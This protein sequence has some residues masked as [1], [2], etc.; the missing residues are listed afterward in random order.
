MN[1]FVRFLAFK[2][3]LLFSLFRRWTK[4]FFRANEE[5]KYKI[6]V[7]ANA[8]IPTYQLG[9]LSPLVEKVKNRVCDINLLTEAQISKQYQT[10][11]WIQKYFDVNQI[12][13][14][15][16]CRYSGPK[17]Q[18]ILSFCKRNK[19]PTLYCI[20]DDLLN[21][22]IEL[23]EKKFQFHNSPERLA[24]VSTLLNSVDVLYTSNARLKERLTLNGVTRKID[25]LDIFCAGEIVQHPI[26]RPIK[27]IGY[28]GFD[29]EHDMKVV[30]PAI[31]RLLR[32][33]PEIRFEL[34]G[35][36]PK[37]SELDEF[38][39]R[40]SVY[41]VQKNYNMFL[42][43]LASLNWSIGI[44]PLAKTPFNL[45]K[46]VN[47]WV[48]YTSAGI[49]VVASKGMIY[50]DCCANQAG[51]LVEEDEWYN[52]L[53]QLIKTPD[54]AYQLC[55]NAQKKL[56]NEFSYNQLNQK[57]VCLLDESNRIVHQR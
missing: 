25:A 42:K 39:D 22:P 49:A 15:I 1:S 56:I 20:D 54:L 7:V 29:H 46:N 30:L 47:K 48:E 38:G 13:H 41:P 21:V 23:G 52:A 40:V 26:S 2:L 5:I 37:P 45:V 35:K 51:L 16:F 10:E 4:I 14:V 27:K 55:L 50:D 33:Y 53:E 28:M 19:V 34:F 9:L 24:S 43:K 36:I 44:C 17:Y 57:L 18:E 3:R 11:K 8:D 12:T 32:N 6:C 31:I